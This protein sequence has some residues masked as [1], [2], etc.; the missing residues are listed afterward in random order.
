[1]KN[2][3]IYETVI[4]F[5]FASYAGLADL[6]FIVIGLFWLLGLIGALGV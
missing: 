6:R 4:T 2:G 1:L 5:D 3:P